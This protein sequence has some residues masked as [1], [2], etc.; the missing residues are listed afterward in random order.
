MLPGMR[1]N[2]RRIFGCR[3]IVLSAVSAPGD[4]RTTCLAPHIVN[5]TGGAGWIAQLYYDYWLFT[6]DERF[7]DERLIPFLRE[8]ALFYEDFVICRTMA[9]M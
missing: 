4:G 8:V 9:G 2:A 7:R 5:W 3:G 1:E 6:R